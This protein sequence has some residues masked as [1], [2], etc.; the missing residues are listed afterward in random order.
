[1][2]DLIGKGVIALCVYIFGESGVDIARVIWAKV[3]DETAVLMPQDVADK[4]PESG[5]TAAEPGTIIDNNEK[6]LD[7]NSDSADT[8]AIN[9]QEDTV[10][11]PIEKPPDAANKSDGTAGAFD[12]I[13]K[14][15]TT[16]I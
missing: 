2:V 6:A 1:M 3:T 9:A 11:G 15:F 5:K 16:V 10:E 13:D 8:T 7:D 14:R 12:V 4:P